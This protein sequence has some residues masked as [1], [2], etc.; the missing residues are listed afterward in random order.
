MRMVTR[1]QTDGI[2]EDAMGGSELE[3][4]KKERKKESD[5]LARSSHTRCGG[6]GS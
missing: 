2:G 1:W 3:L 6:G 4:G 5:L